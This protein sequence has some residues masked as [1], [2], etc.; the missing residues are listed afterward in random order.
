[1]RYQ[2]NMERLTKL[3]RDFYRVSGVRI[4]VFS[5]E[6]RQIAAIPEAASRFCT[7]LRQYPAIA[8]QCLDCDAM[9]FAI[10]GS[11][12]SIAVIWALW[13]QSRLS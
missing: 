9:R 8:Q 10:A 4:G 13:R 5:R 12:P 6:Y 3:L 2:Y 11:S 1:M 7:R